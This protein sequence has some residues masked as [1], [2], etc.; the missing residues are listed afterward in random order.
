MEL[1]YLVKRVHSNA[2]VGI[3]CF[4]VFLII[5]CGKSEPAT[6]VSQIPVEFNPVFVEKEYVL[7]NGDEKLEYL[8]N[9]IKSEPTNREDF[10]TWLQEQI[11][12]LV[13]RKE[14]YTPAK[15]F[16][17]SYALYT[18]R[19]Y[20]SSVLWANYILD[21]ANQDVYEPAYGMASAALTEFY[22]TRQDQDSISKYLTIM[23]SQMERDTTSWF[24]IA[25]FGHKAA[26]AEFK[27]D[28]FNAVV[29]YYQALELIPEEDSYKRFTMHRN[30][31]STYITMDF[32]KKAEFH[33]N[34]AIKILPIDEMPVTEVLTFSTIESKVGNFEKADA[35][36]MRGIDYAK[37]N[38][39]VA[40]L[41]Q[42][43]SN[44][45]NHKRREGK[46]DEALL[47]MDKSDSI[48]RSLGLDIGLAINGINR[49][50]VFYNMELPKQALKEIK[51][52]EPVV[53][54]MDLVYLTMEY[55]QLLYFIY[56]RLGMEEQANRSFRTFIGYKEDFLGDISKS[57]IVEWELATQREVF[58]KEAG[59]LSL[60]LERETKNKY[61]V[62]FLLS[63]LVLVLSVFY[64]IRNRRQILERENDK[65]EKEK[66]KHAL[67]TKSK[68]LLA[69]SLN[70][71]S[72]QNARLE[73]L[74]ELN[75]I[76][77][78]LPVREQKKFSG[79]TYKLG[80][81]KNTGFFEE[82]E[83]RFKGVYEGFYDRILTMAPDLT[84]NELRICAFIRLNITTKDIAVLTG[85]SLGT[86]E[87]TRIAI[88]KKLG[89]D[90]QENLQQFLLNL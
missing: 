70:N 17:L 85:K 58:N 57:A 24:K 21:R 39:L 31:A 11:E 54:Q 71:L 52:A 62:G 68:E 64:F 82:F 34:E 45:G 83:T 33:A 63:I 50:E 37:S 15:L 29:N 76:V 6:K 53:V 74:E 88:R 78:K 73:I 2:V 9:L 86:I 79:L 49:A 36:F 72:V 69:E 1:R 10:K 84:P 7:K 80:T 56:D 5:S 23:E 38:S 90:S 67:E 42:N 46:Y 30:L 48:C 18:G 35:L 61:L 26:L 3:S 87:N 27:G 59:N 65:L 32:I 60:A 55:Y 19:Y 75:P 89:M 13:K 8:T 44:Y 47:Y 66:L 16:E 20:N 14:P 28:Y 25:Y 77:D 51:S 41:A 40:L 22:V 12:N 81:S 4:F 43:Y